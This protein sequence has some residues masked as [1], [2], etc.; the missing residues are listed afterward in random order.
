MLFISFERTLIMAYID[1]MGMYY[2]S[3]T[4]HEIYLVSKERVITN[5]DL[6]DFIN[7]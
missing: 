7:L 3:I 1:I 4:L 6:F 5:N 2:L